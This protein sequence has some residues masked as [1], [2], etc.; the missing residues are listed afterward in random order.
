MNTRG[1]HQGRSIHLIDIENQL[2]TPFFCAEAVDAWFKDY[3][4]RVDYRTG[5][6]VVVGTSARDT[7]WEVERSVVPCRKIF[8]V[9][10][11]GADRALQEVMWGE[12]LPTRFDRILCA[13]GDGG[14]TD[15][16]IA[17]GCLGA[18]VVVVSRSSCLS[19]RLRLAATEV[20]TLPEDGFY[21]PPAA[22]QAA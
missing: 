15:V 8:R 19:K 4:R 17:L 16:V 14:F 7:V 11:D 2:G 22:Q 21:T 3:V 5:D 1:I 10:V 13:S 18:H 9:G 6:L 12:E 20:I